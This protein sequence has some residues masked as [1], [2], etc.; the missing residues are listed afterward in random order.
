VNAHRAFVLAGLIFTTGCPIAPSEVEASL[1]LGAKDV[2]YRATL[3][4]VRVLNAGPASALPVVGELM[5]PPADMLKEMGWLGR[6]TLYRWRATDAGLDLDLEGS[7]SRADW[8]RCAQATCD[9]G[10][11][12]D[13]FPFE[14]CGGAYRLADAQLLRLGTT[15][16]KWPLDAGVISFRAGNTEEVARTGVSAAPIWAIIT[17]QPA[18][19]R[20]AD[21]W[22]HAFFEAH[23]SGRLPELKKLLAEPAIGGAD[24]QRLATDGVRGS[25]QRLLWALLSDSEAN[26]ELQDPPGGRPY[27]FTNPYRAFKPKKLSSLAAFKLRTAYDVAQVGWLKT[28]SLAENLELIS[29]ACKDKSVGEK[30][31]ALLQMK[32]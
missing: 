8:D 30:A 7:F 1:T 6:P 27:I 15:P 22:L 2:K 16:E 25:R 26:G 14:G 3:K 12:C 32:R 31:C 18:E 24:L 5:E 17:A 21:Q 11:R 20:R 9:G 28:G 19:A 29:S 23:E 4:D 10:N 13:S